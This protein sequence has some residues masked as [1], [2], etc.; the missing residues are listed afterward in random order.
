MVD[1]IDFGMTYDSTFSTNEGSL[2]SLTELTVVETS[3]G[4]WLGAIG[5]KTYGGVWCQG[6]FAEGQ[7]EA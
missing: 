7:L 3:P 4:G 6:N 5:G 2:F 1:K